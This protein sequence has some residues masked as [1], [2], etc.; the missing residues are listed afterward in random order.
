MVHVVIAVLAVP[1][2]AV[3]VG[4]GIQLLLLL[5]TD[6]GKVA[7]I[8]T[9]FLVIVGFIIIRKIVDIKV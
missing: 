5:T 3:E 8:G 2:D 1:S 6:I 4:N 9:V 7:I